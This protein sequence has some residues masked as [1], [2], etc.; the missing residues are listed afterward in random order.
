MKDL[1]APHPTQPLPLKETQM[2]ATH[3]T[4]DDDV[5]D[6]AAHDFLIAR[7]VARS[8]FADY[9]ASSVFKQ[10]G[11]TMAKAYLNLMT[12]LGLEKGLHV[13]PDGRKGWTV[14]VERSMGRTMLTFPGPMLPR[15]TGLT[16][17][18]AEAYQTMRDD[19]LTAMGI[20]A[21]ALGRTPGAQA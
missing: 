13:S 14:R 7:Q 19:A 9:G 12:M 10:N 11:D 1:R 4:V 3:F 15:C 20:S 16:P 2:Q 18:T 5:I 8:S 21:A 17:V 6:D